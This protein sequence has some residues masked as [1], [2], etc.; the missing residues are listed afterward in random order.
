MTI[1]EQFLTKSK[2]AKLVE[3][4]VA[5]L[6]IP[7]MD[8]VLHLC[9]KNGIEPEDIRKFISPTIKGKIEA[10]AMQLNFLPRT[11]SLDSAFFD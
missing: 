7:Y 2:F 3:A 4:T 8:A 11:N 6:K 5:E 10:E 9:D 1:E